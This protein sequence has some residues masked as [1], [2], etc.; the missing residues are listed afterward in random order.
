MN[1]SISVVIP[2]YNGKE[3]LEANLPA[4]YHALHTSGITDYE[5]II[6]DDA[7]SDN[8]VKF[9]QTKYPYILL[10]E[11]AT[12]QGFAGNT[13]AGIFK[14]SKE[15]ILIL[16]SDV[17]LTTEYFNPLLSYFDKPDTFGV[18]GLITSLDSDK[19]QDGAKYPDYSFG[20]IKTSMNYLCT[21]KTSLYTFF[22]SGANALVDRKK[23]VELGAFSELY[24]PYYSEDVDLGL[25]AWRAGY[26]C[27]FEQK[28][29]CKHPNS[30]TIEKEPSKKVKIIAKRNK[31]YLPF[32]HL[33]NTELAYFL[34]VL[35]LKAFFRIFLLDINYLKS[36]YLFL[37][38]INKCRTAK[39]A[40]A[41]LQKKKNISITV[42]NV[43]DEIK[44]NIPKKGIEKF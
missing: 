31:M 20:N 17:V 25:K 12:N 3:L 5:I 11:N 18:M 22:M 7:S 42:R 30:A 44:R 8:S 6:T 2:N 35:F 37:T 19:I 23:I 39:A 38:S 40:I 28:A 26:K 43:V 36:Y 4:V 21:E 13:N 32:I 33:Q 15:L 29:V 1:R 10:I 34:V 41:A 9:I 27:Y 24:N 14:A 16:N